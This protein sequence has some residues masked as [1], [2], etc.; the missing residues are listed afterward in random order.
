[1]PGET[2]ELEQNKATEQGNLEGWSAA[3]GTLYTLCTGNTEGIG[4]L[5]G[6]PSRGV[7]GEQERMVPGE[8]I[9]QQT[10]EWSP[11]QELHEWRKWHSPKGQAL[12]SVL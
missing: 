10:R 7:G 11:L 1:M 4:T 5:L 9:E 2:T 12:I 8:W 6:L 3:T